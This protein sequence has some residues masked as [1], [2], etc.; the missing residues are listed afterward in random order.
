MNEPS[1][2]SITMSVSGRYVHG[3]A[4][5]QASVTIRGDGG[6]DHC[7]EAFKAFLV[8]AGFSLETA[9]KLDGLDA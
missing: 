6:L 9:R 8:A 4:Q 2:H 1:T 3:Q 5:E 7:I